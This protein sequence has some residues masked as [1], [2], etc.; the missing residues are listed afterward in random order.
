LIVYSLLDWQRVFILIAHPQDL[1][2]Q[3]QPRLNRR[4]TS[5]ASSR[6][7][8]AL[9]CPRRQRNARAN[10]SLTLLFL[11][12]SSLVKKKPKATEAAAAADPNQSGHRHPQLP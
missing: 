10:P 7:L 1:E 9:L 5:G 6:L 11:S 3:Q 2:L 12:R 8:P 4:L